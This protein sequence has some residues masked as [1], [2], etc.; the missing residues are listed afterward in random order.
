MAKQEEKKKMTLIKCPR[1]EGMGVVGPDAVDCEKCNAYGEIEADPLM[2]SKDEV[3]K[4]R[5][6]CDIKG[7]VSPTVLDTLD[8]VLGKI[9]DE[10]L[11]RDS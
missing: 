10:E 7:H 1:C 2:K 8:W 11:I 5:I 4:M 9:T 6:I 3:L